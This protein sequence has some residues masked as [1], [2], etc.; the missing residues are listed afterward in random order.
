MLSPHVK[1]T[2]IHSRDM[3]LSSE[4]LPHDFKEQTLSLLQDA[5]VETIMGKRVQST[6]EPSDTDKKTL[7]LS[8]D[9]EIQVTEVINAVSGPK[10]TTSYLPAELLNAD[11]E[12]KV[13]PNLSLVSGRSSSAFHFAVGDLIPQSGI[14]RCE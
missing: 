7:Y 3:L 1:V 2:L 12:V 13:K 14:K 8:D 6:A 4:P 11:G 10:P 9:T 5:G